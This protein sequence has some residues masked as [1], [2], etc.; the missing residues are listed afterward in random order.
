VPH[1]SRIAKVVI[2]VP[3][4]DHDRNLEFWQGAAGVKLEQSQNS[5]Q[6]HGGR[7]PGMDFELLFQRLEHGSSR[8]HL[9][10]HTSDLEAEVARLERLGASR[11]RHVRGLWIMQDPAGLP[12]CVIPDRTG[13]LDDSNAQRWE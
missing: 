6:Y 2:D 5:P 11:V 1:Y 9:D 7:L 13:T 4:P 12:F 3:D 10:I 8:V